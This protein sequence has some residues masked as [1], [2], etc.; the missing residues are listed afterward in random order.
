MLVK[1]FDIV[2]VE[3]SFVAGYST[4][5]Q[6]SFLI[7]TAFFLGGLG[8]GIFF[9]SA[10]YNYYIGALIGLVVAIAGKGIPHL[11][12]LGRP[13][14]FLRAFLK[15]KTSWISRGFISVAVLGIFGILYL[16]PFCFEL[17]GSA[18]I[19]F[20]EGGSI[21]L[22]LKI[23]A[24]LAC[25]VAITYDGYLLSTIRAIPFW[26]TPLLPI[27][28]L[29]Y[30]FLGGTTFIFLL[31]QYKI[32]DFAALNIEFIHTI[33][34]I[35]VVL[36]FILLLTFI[37]AMHN[38]TIAARRTVSLLL[39]GKYSSQFIGLVIV[40]GLIVM[41]GLS[42]YFGATGLIHLIPGVVIAELIGDFTLIF[43][44]LR[45]GVF[46]PEIY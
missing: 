20:S 35:L 14:R 29:A 36:N 44:I 12:Y 11:I 33:E 1:E 37:Y 23:I 2:E 7:T 8:G 6:W 30:S 24:L 9:V 32:G 42:F 39:K 17:A 34:M 41:F 16:L 15:P 10:I 19:I 13:E 26:N 40:V 46:Y 4:Q 43:V 5:R 18:Y 31:S 45:G 25:F 27:L 38:S 22:S 21:W 28:F 3:D